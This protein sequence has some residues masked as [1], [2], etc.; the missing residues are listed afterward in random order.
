MILGRVAYQVPLG[1][2]NIQIDTDEIAADEFGSELSEM[3]PFEEHLP[4]IEQLLASIGLD[5]FS[6][7]SL[8]HGY[9][10]QNCV[11]ALKNPLNDK[12]QY[13]LRVPVLPDEEDGKCVAIDNDVALLGLLADKLPVPRVKA[14]SATADNAIEKPYTVQTRLPGQSLDGLWEDMTREDK[15]QIVDQFVELLATI[16]SITFATAGKFTASPLPAVVTDFVTTATPT[17]STFL[18]GDEDFIKDPQVLL[19]RA[20]PHTKAL[21]RSHINGWIPQDIKDGKGEFTTPLYNQLLKIID[22]LD[23]KGAF[24]DGPAPIVLHHWDLEPRNIMVDNLDGKW[25]ICGVIDWDDCVALPRPLARRAPDWIWDFDYEAFTG[26]LD[27]DHEPNPNLSEE[28]QALKSYFDMKAA[29]A[30]P[31]YLEDA[32]GHGIWLR[33]IWTF[34]RGG[35][36]SMW[37]IELMQKMQLDWDARPEKLMTLE[38]RNP[39]LLEPEEI[40]EPTVIE[41]QPVEQ[42]PVV[43]EAA[44]QACKTLRSSPEVSGRS[45]L[46]GF[47][48]VLR[49]CALN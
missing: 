39:I 7:E 35:G 31:G 43:F 34:A 3:E 26:Y 23:S 37:Y 17:I 4:K 25:K 41:Q 1:V 2:D 6:V 32:Y 20:G 38:P 46:T 36:G 16:E 30:L 42:Q 13:I 40:A 27:N 47:R 10:F 14:Y 49:L 18:E 21:L 22:E 12:E 29:A 33:R 5:G 15:H 45:R 44:R 28:Q 11:Y 9:T 19:D 24:N 8:Q 48:R